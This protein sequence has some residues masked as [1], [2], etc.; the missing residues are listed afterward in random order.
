MSP[1]TPHNNYGI[2]P[3]GTDELIAQIRAALHR[4]APAGEQAR[5]VTA[6]F[7]VDL[8]AK[9]IFTASGETKLSYA[10]AAR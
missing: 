5:V 2:K 4:T 6:D 9:R 8:T 1:V 7:T 3:F 10:V